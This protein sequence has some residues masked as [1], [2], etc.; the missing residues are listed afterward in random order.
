MGYGFVNRFIDRLHTPLGTLSNYS[1]IANFHTSQIPT[2]PGKPFSSL[3]CL[4]QPTPSNGFQQW[5]FFTFQH[6]GPRHSGPCRNQLNCHMD[7]NATSFQPL[8]QN[9]TEL[10]TLSWLDYPSSLFKISS[11]RTHRKYRSSIVAC[12]NVFIEPLFRNSG[13]FICLL[14]SNGC[15][16]AQKRMWI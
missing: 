16:V 4:N 8:L 6:S 1:A 7:Y 14:H 2:A 10:A 5:R 3:S 15:A 13:L 12:G 9:S 11:A